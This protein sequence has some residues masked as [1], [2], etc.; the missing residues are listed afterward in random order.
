VKICINL[1]KKQFNDR[2]LIDTINAS[3]TEA[4]FGSRFM[5]LEITESIVMHNEHKIINLLQSIAKLGIQ[6]S[7]DDFGTGYSSFSFL[8]DF[9]INILKIDRSFIKDLKTESHREIAIIK[10]I[11]AVAKSLD[12]GII[13]EGVETGE[14]LTIMHGLDCEVIQGFLLSKP[15]PAE[16]AE[17]FLS[18]GDR[19]PEA[20]L[21]VFKTCA[22]Q[23][24]PLT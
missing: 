14:Q 5:E 7:M 4:D 15:V 10:A 16:E 20:D 2:S 1:S 21:S 18:R 12:L 3:L 19:G 9:P 22:G 6:L 17:R 13:A 8:K 23:G 11:I 24:G